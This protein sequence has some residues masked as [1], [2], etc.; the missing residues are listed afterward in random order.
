MQCSEEIGRLEA[1][2]AKAMRVMI[3]AKSVEIGR[4]CEST[5]LPVPDLSVL[6]DD[7]ESPGQVADVLS[8]LMR[9]VAEVATLVEKREPV[10]KVIQEVEDSF[11]ESLWHFQHQQ[12]NL[13]NSRVRAV[14]FSHASR[15]PRSRMLILETS[16]RRKQLACC[17]A[18]H[19]TTALVLILL[20]CV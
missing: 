19:P 1:E 11:K 7:V 12:E 4:L 9:M 8:K 18:W 6:V 2:Q 13:F 14:C 20:L 16:L 17:C 3:Q 15:D 10:I 5:W